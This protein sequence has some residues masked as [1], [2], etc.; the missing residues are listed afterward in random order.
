MS[1]L[2]QLLNNKGTISSKLGKALAQQVLDADSA[3]LDEAV[4]L[5]DHDDKNVRAGAAK[6]VEQ[7]AVK[8]PDL[9][10]PYLPQLLDALDA[11]EPQ[12]RWMAIHTLGLCADQDPEVALQAMPH[13]QAYL[14][15]NSGACLRGSTLT[16]LGHAGATSPEAALQAFPLL[17]GALTTLPRQTKN[18]LAAFLRLLDQADDEM[19]A[20]I[21]Q[22]AAIYADDER[23]NVRAAARRL[24]KQ[25]KGRQ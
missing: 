4:T 8:R 7:V 25:V 6:I 18:V 23:P 15:A 22:H 19:Q 20:R 12:T 21:A 16:Y 11:P 9:V 2:P 17:E 24:A 3:I 14:E 1:I 5:L 13:A 10:R